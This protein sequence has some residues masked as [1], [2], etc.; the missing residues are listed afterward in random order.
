MTS[1]N[2]PTKRL[3]CA[4]LSFGGHAGVEVCFG[5]GN[6]SIDSIETLRELASLVTAKMCKR[7]PDQVVAI[8]KPGVSRLRNGAE[9]RSEIL[10]P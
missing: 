3:D 6:T 10:L 5:N 9:A 2:T 1:K 4:D 8:P 7:N